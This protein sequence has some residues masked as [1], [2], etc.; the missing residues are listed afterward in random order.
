MCCFSRR[1]DFVSATRIFASPFAS[2]RQ[3]LVYSMRIGAPE[4]LAMIL[5]IPVTRGVSEDAVHFV[6]LQ[7]YPAFFDDIESGFLRPAAALPPD[8]TRGS[9]R[10]TLKVIEVGDFVASFVPQESD[11]DRLDP[12]FRL[13]ADVWSKLRQYAMY[14]FAVFELKPGRARIHPMAFTFPSRLS[15]KLFFPTVH[16]HD[17]RFH[18][19]ARFDHILYCQ[20]TRTGQRALSQWQESDAPAGRFVAV[21]KTHGLVAENRHLFR[22]EMTGILA[23]EDVILWAT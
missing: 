16:I 6:D 10:T 3:V 9:A 18:P 8:S 13:P 23:N 19:R 17:G 22:N 14:G 15:G 2:G 12:R 20:P 1:V 7:N 11:F 21:K 4:E 5:P